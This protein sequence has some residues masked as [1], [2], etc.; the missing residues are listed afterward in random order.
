VSSY[1][2]PLLIA[3]DHAGWDLKNKL[4]KIRTDLNWEDLGCLSTEKT[5][6]PDYADKLCQALTKYKFGVLI[7]GTGQ[8]MNIKANRYPHVRAALC[9]NKVIS[10]LSRSH[11]NANVLCLPGR[12]LN[13]EE[14]LEILDVFLNTDFDDQEAYKRRVK[15]LSTK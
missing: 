10:R 12:F 3:S 9:W 6:Y 8:G 14:A 15:K 4:K 2:F 7:C 13:S 1:S 5:D 11:N